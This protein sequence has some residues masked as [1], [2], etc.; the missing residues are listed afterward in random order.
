MDALTTEERFKKGSQAVWLGMAGNVILT[1]IKFFAGIVG[2]SQ[3]MIAD[4]V[5]SFSDILSTSVVLVGLRVSRKPVDA[6]HPYGHGKAEPLATAIVGSIVVIAGLD[7]LYSSTRFLIIGKHPPGLIAL[8]V[9]PVSILINEIIYRYISA[10]AKK[11]GSTV[12]MAN[13]WD[14][15]KDAIS[16]IATLFGIAGARLGFPLLDPLV[17]ALVSFMIMKIGYDVISSAA[18]ELMDA[19]PLKPSSQQI[20]AIA[21]KCEGV[22]HAFVRAR[23]MGQFVLVDMKIDIDPEFTISQGHAIAKKVKTCVMQE[24]DNVTDVM[25]HVNPHYD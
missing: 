5:E 9:A 12:I 3:A 13:A 24:L 22:E 4:A 10:T 20:I 19:A 11:L 23:R 8:A 2:H 18:K 1:V 7:I 14:Y 16:S 25:V 15:R 17:A 6:E 21:E